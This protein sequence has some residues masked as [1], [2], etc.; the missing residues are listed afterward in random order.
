MRM[1]WNQPDVRQSSR[2]GGSGGAGGGGS[3]NRG[4]ASFER[5]D[6]LPGSVGTED[7]SRLFRSVGNTARGENPDLRGDLGI[8]D[9]M[10]IEDGK[11][12]I[13]EEAKMWSRDDFNR[14]ADLDPTEMMDNG[15]RKNTGPNSSRMMHIQ[16]IKHH[17]SVEYLQQNLD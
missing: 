3:N 13:I 8:P 4:H 6:P 1:D 16:M 15:F 17:R 9:D 5:H 7:T 14:Y 2:S 10:V 12:T 11:I